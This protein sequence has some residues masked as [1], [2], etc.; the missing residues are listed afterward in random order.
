MKAVIELYKNVVVQIATPYSTGTGFY[1]HDYQLIVT[2]DHVVRDN[3]E[4]VVDGMAFEKQLAKVVFSDPKYDLAFIQAP[5]DIDMPPVPLAFDL[6]LQEGD[7]VLAIGH[8]FGLKYNAIQGNISS[9]RHQQGDIDYLKHSAALAPGNSGG[10][11]V[12]ADSQIVGVNTFISQDG[13]NIGFSLPVAQLLDAIDAYQTK[14]AEVSARCF[15]CSNVVAENEMDNRYCPHCGSRLEMPS[16]ADAYEPVGVAKTIEDLL[17]NAGHQV[18]LSRRGPNNWQIRQGS[19]KIN[20]SYYEKTGLIIGDAYLCSLPQK[21]IKP[22]YEYLL[23][24]NYEI[25]NL[26]FSVRGQ[27]ITLSLLIYDRYLN[28]D[29][30]MALFTH[31]FEKADDYD[32]ILVEEYGAQWRQEEG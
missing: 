2:N 13:D 10:P 19:A 7:Q 6:N 26:T 32:N 8:P 21:D 23:R 20:I 17:A 4:V 28:L 15:N 16:A 25:E 12:N 3:R 5:K 31:L 18:D 11:L 1:L 22:L 29:T 30:G 27:D 24:Q 9:V 14:R